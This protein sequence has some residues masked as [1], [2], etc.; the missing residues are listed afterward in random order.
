MTIFMKR[1]GKEFVIHGIFV[2]DMKHVPTA[3]YLLDEFLGK[4]SRDF[5]ITG[6]HHLMESFIGLDIEQSWSKIS[7]HLNAYIQET[8]DIYKAHPGTKMIRLKTEP[9]NVLTSAPTLRMYRKCQTRRDRRSM[10]NFYRSMVVRLQMRWVRFD[11][12]YTVR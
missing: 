4:H 8:L 11:I 1:D 3:K 9:D 10:M 12:S 2:D 5:E 7:L 6:G